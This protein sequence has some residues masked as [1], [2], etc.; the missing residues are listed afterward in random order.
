MSENKTVSRNGLLIDYE[1]CTGC[2]SC[3]VACMKELKLPPEQYGIRVLEDGPRKTSKGKWDWTYLPLPTSLCDLCE[4]RVNAGK[5]P[6]CVQHCQA[7]IMT[8]GSVEE[9]SKKLAEK[10]KMVLFTPI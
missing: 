9:L 3:E 7:A 8:Y 5:K 4:E 6:S 1:F 10:P 2:H